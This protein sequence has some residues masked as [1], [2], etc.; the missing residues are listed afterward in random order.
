MN[1]LNSTTLIIDVSNE[2]NKKKRKRSPVLLL[3]YRKGWNGL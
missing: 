3:Q 2:R 1:L